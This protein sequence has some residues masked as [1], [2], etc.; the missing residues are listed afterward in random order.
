[1]RIKHAYFELRQ[2]QD[3]VAIEILSDAADSASEEESGMYLAHRIKL[4]FKVSLDF[5]TVVEK[6]G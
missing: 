5:I 1:M 3:D 6:W 2:G 4:L